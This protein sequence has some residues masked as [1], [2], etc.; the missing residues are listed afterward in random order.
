MAVLR[1]QLGSEYQVEATEV[2]AFKV[3]R[4]AMSIAKVRVGR[5]P[6]GGTVF[7]VTG[8]GF[9]VTSRVVNSRHIGRLVATAIQQSP[10]L[11]GD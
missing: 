8:G 2:D 7:N 4:S 10:E 5:S 3:R 9:L 1:S 6:E 11:N